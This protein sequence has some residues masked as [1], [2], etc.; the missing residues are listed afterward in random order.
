LE[1]TI[2]DLA[3]ALALEP[4]EHLSLVGGGGKTTLMFSLAHEL[5]RQG[6]RVITSTTT[7]IWHRE[8]MDSDCIIF[9]R[10]DEAWRHTVRER[11]QIHGHLFVAQELLD[12][13]K[14]KGID[15]SLADELHRERIAD[16]LLVEADGAAGHPVKAPDDHEPV[17]PS[18][19]TKVVAMMG[20]EAVGKRFGSEIVFRADRFGRLTG[21]TT[22]QR[23]TPPILAKLFLD[24]RG[25]F[26]GTPLSAKRLVFLNKL[27]L[28]AEDQEARELVDLIMGSTEKQV[29]RVVIGSV[30]KNS[31][32]IFEGN[33]ERYL[34]KDRRT[35]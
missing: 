35:A 14:V 20:L 13:G 2:S 18:S 28:L 22:G 5:C 9:T 6:K 29:D 30:T 8:A 27:D 21:L 25:V 1:K 16:Y 4:G 15:P 23:L 33:D 32:I 3:G 19:A 26:K 17:I 10:S 11:I 7:K 24:P 34:H 12:S 31:Y